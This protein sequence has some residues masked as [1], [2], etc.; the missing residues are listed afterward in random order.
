MDDVWSKSVG[1]KGLG[2]NPVGE[3]DRS[4]LVERKSFPIDA[5]SIES[6]MCDACNN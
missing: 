5:E 3:G 1:V 4:S 6:F 2:R